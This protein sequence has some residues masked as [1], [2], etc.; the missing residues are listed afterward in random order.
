MKA[1]PNGR[2]AEGERAGAPRGLESA[3][4]RQVSS[5]TAGRAVAQTSQAAAPSLAHLLQGF[6]NLTASLASNVSPEQAAISFR[7]MQVRGLSVGA[8]DCHKLIVQNP[9]RP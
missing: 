9:V 7:L 4:V 1:E 8:R 6:P 5:E 2:D 3:A